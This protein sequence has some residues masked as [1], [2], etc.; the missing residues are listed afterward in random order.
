MASDG[1]PHMN[2]QANLARV[3]KGFRGGPFNSNPALPPK[4]TFVEGWPASV[5]EKLD[6]PEIPTGK[7]FDPWV[8]RRP[9]SSMK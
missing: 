2:E 6:A 5:S 7:P 3:L 8:Q 1:V 9:N 4:L